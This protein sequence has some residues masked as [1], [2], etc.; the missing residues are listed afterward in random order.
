[1][2]LSQSGDARNVDSLAVSIDVQ[3][4]LLVDHKVALNLNKIL[5][6]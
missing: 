5:I 1:V 2:V 6:D 3:H 4:V